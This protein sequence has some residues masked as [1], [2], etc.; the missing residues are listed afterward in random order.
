MLAETTRFFRTPKGLLIL[1]LLVLLGVAVTAD[2]VGVTRAA[3][4]L[5]SAVAAAIIVDAPI[6]RWREGRWVIPDGAILTGMI[7]AMVLSP[8][9]RWWVAAITSALAIASKYVI[10]TRSA[11]VFNPAALALVVTFYLFD[12]AQSWWGAVPDS[13]LVGLAAL[14]ATGLFITQRVNKI[15]LVLSFFGVYYSLFTITTFVGDP[16]HLA[17]VYR[18]P[19]LEAALYFAFFMLTDPPTS[20]PKHGDQL[21][22]GGIA[23]ATSFA[24]FE[25]VGAAYFLLAGLLVANLWEARR[26]VRTRKQRRARTFVESAADAPVLGEV[27]PA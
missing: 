21:V 7:V 25:L 11:N 6:L 23:A 4:V 27:P 16:G 3:P 18:T 5:L 22:N 8:F 15:P 24:V 20:P 12:T 2:G 1:V 17:E 13:G 9:E 19:D 26:R 14:T 10:R